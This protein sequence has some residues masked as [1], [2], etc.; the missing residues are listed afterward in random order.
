MVEPAPL[1]A[2]RPRVWPVA[3]MHLQFTA[4]LPVAGGIN[5]AATMAF[6]PA[7]FVECLAHKS[8]P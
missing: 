1:H 6:G 7:L 3:L 8:Q 4:T 5:G 2:A